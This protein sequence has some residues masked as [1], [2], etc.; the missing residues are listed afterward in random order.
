MILLLC[1]CT[2][3]GSKL[4]L[5]GF[6]N[7]SYGKSVAADE[8]KESPIDFLESLVLGEVSAKLLYLVTVL[9]F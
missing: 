5:Y 2:V 8:T 1:V 3:E 4:P 9:L 7:L 6:K